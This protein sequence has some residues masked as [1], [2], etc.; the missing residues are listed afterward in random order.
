MTAPVQSRDQHVEHIVDVLMSE[1]DG[2]VPP[3]QVVAEA[4]RAYRDLCDTSRV[5]SFIP[6]LALRRA[7]GS[8]QRTS[9][10]RS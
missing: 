4:N 10:V 8:L 7:R 3:D 2:E 9:R 6:I 5:E 1:F